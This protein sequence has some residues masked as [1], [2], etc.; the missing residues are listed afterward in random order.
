MWSQM[1][2]IICYIVTYENGMLLE[3]KT[4]YLQIFILFFQVKYCFNSYIN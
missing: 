1:D 3:N 4:Q 2:K